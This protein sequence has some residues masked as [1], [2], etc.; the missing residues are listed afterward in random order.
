MQAYRIETMVQQDGSLLVRNLPLQAGE[1]VEIIILI[2]PP[3]TPTHT[4]YPLHDIPLTYTDPTASVADADWEA[5][6]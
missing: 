1:K 3:V 2:H 4:R 6:Q 5:T